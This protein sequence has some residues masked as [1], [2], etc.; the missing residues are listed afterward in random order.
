VTTIDQTPKALGE[1]VAELTRVFEAPVRLVWE[2]WTQRDYM[3]RW[4]GPRGLFISHCEVDFRPGGRFEI[5]YAGPDGTAYPP[6]IS[7]FTEIVPHEKLCW[8]GAFPGSGLEEQLKTTV[9]FEDL[10]ERTRVQVR[11]V[12]AVTPGLEMA[13]DGMQQGWEQTLDRLGESLAYPHRIT[14]VSDTEVRITRSFK[15]PARFVFD[16]F[17]KP[18]YLSRWYGCATMT[19]SVCE[20][21]LRPGGAYRWTLKTEEGFDCCFKGEYLEVERPERLVYTEQFL[22]GDE[23]TPPLHTTATFDERDGQTTMELKLVYTSKA[24]RDGHMGSGMESGMA[25]SHRR[26]EE[27]LASMA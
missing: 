7:V 22:L 6:A 19:M 21:D 16:A 27:M 23:W 2:A 11:Q 13:A 25:E 24:H 12:F 5:G 3:M 9:T 14:F 1:R 18:E 10:G 20:I 15:A 26:I 8:V 4:F 17:T